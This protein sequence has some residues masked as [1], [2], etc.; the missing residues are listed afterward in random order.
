MP[1]QDVNGQNVSKLEYFINADPGFG[2]GVNVP[3]TASTDVTANFQVPVTSFPKGFHQLF[4]RSFVTPYQ[5]TIDGKVFDKGGWSLTSSRTF[6]KETFDVAPGTF[7]N[8]T[9]GEYFADTDPGFG[10]GVN[11]PVTQGADLTNV[12][13]AFDVT[14]LSTGFHNLFVRFK[15][16]AGKWGLTSVRSF[17]KQNLGNAGGILPNVVKG[18]YFADTD[19]GFGKGINLPF[20]AGQDLTN[21]A[22]S[23]DV[24][25]LTNGFHNI[26]TRFQDANGRWSLTSS[27]SFYKQTLD[28]PG[29]TLPNIIKGEYFADTDPGFGKGVNIP[30]TQAQDLTN[31]AFAFNITALSNGF[32]NLFV[33]F[34]DAKGNWGQTTSRSFYKQ[35]LE[36][37]NSIPPNIVQLEYFVDTD[38]GFN[39]GKKVSITAGQ[40]LDMTFPLN[41]NE[42]SVGN[43]T[44]Y[45]RAQDAKGN[46][47]LVN[48]GTFKVEP[49]S[50]LIVSLGTL[51]TN[52]CAGL[53]VKVP[54]SVNASFGSNNIFTAQLSDASGGFSN[55]VNIGNFTGTTNDTVR[56]TIPAN[57][58]AGSLYRIRVIAS[59]PFDTSGA[60]S[61]LVIK[62]V[63]EQSF[64]ITGKTATCIG[65]QAYSASSIEP[66]TTFS[67][68]L[69]GGGTM[70]TNGAN[71]TITWTTAGTHTVSLTPSN[72]CGNGQVRTLQVTVFTTAPALV[73]TI[74]VNSRL[75]TASGPVSTTYNGYQWYLNNVIINGAT[76]STYNAVADGSYSVAFT[77]SCGTGSVSVAV[78]MST[79]QSQ[80]I[81]FDPITTKVFGVAPFT[82]KAVASSGLAVTYSIVSGPATI[83]GST[84][85]I[86]GAGVVTVRAN[87]AGNASYN[88]AFADI[89]FT[90]DKAPATITLNTLSQVYTGI[91]KTPGFTTVPA[92]LQL[93]FT[94]NGSATPPVNAGS[95]TVVA[96]V[97]SANYSGTSQGTF[98]ITKATNLITLESIPDKEYGIS[99]FNVVANASSGLPVTLSLVTTPTGIAS[100]SA[101]T[102]SIT[103]IGSVQVNANQAGDGNYLP[104]T[105]VSDLFVINKGSQLVLLDP[106]ADR[107]YE[108]P[109][110]SV[111]ATVSTGLPLT[112]SITTNPLSGVASISGKVITL[113][114]TKGSVTVKASQAGNTLYQPASSERTFNVLGKSQT[115]SFPA[116]SSKVFGDAPFTISATASSGL[117]VVFYI[118]SGPATI[119]GNTITLTGSG[120]VVVQANQTGNAVYSQAPPI[121]QAFT[122]IKKTV[123]LAIQT[124]ASAQTEIAPGDS[125][126]LTWK[127]ANLGNGP[128]FINWTERIYMQSTA[129]DNRTLLQQSDY[130]TAGQLPNGQN[131]S[132][133]AKV[134]IPA[135]FNIGAQGVFVVEVVPGATIEE[136]AATLANNT[137]IQLTPWNIKKLLSIILS[138]NELT[139][140]EVNG[141]TATIQRTGSLA[142]SL[143]VNL[144]LT[145]AS[146]FSFPAQAVIPAGQSGT[147]VV[148]KALNNVLPEGII[149]DTLRATSTG[150][151]AAKAGLSIVDDDK[152]NLSFANLPLT[153]SEG[154][155]ATFQVKTNLAPKS[156]LEVFLT[157]SNQLRLPVPASVIIPVGSLSVNVNFIL[158]QDLV[159]EIDLTATLTAGAANHNSANGTVQVKDDDLPNLALVFQTNIIAESGGYYAT[160]ATLKRTGG[161]PVAFS[162]LLSSSLSNTLILPAG[163]SLEANENEKT[164][165]V[166]VIDNALVDGLRNVA[167]TASISVASCGCS[168]PPAT[169]GSVTANINVSDND[170]P[171][172]VLTATPLTLPEGAVYGAMLRVTRNTTT[173]TAVTVNLSSSDLTEATVP[174]S[175]I[176]PIGASFAEVPVTT[177]NDGVADGNQ[178]VYF[179]ATAGGFS[180][181]SVWVVVSDLNKPDLQI[182][183]VTLSKDSVQAMTL[184][185]YQVGVKNTGFATASS[186]VIMR[187]Y[188]SA[189]NVI[190]NNDSLVTVDTIPNAIPIGST[191]QVVNA[192]N[193]PNLPG[194]YKMIF[195]VNADLGLTELLL[196]NNISTPVNLFIKPDYTAT[197]S[198]TPVYVL[199]GNAVP[200]T[201]KALKSNGTP[202]T[203][204]PVE[205]YI[206]TQGFRRTL[207][208]TT[209][210]TGTYA[211]SFVP[212]INESGHY[213][214]GA[215]FPGIGSTIEQDAF[216]IVGV[217]VNN[218]EIA[219]FKVILNDTLRGSLSVTNL[220]NRSL[221]NFSLLPVSLPGGAYIRFE[222]VPSFAG[223]ATIAL[224]Y[225][226]SGASLSPGVNFEVAGLEAKSAEGTI[227][228]VEAFYYCQAPSAYIVA[229]ITKITVTASQTNKERLVEFRLVNK[230]QGSTGKVQLQLPQVN[231]MTA[232]TPKEIPFLAFGDTALVIL[233]FSAL[234]EVPFNFPITGNI[235]IN[236]AN[237]NSIAL[238]YS[239]EKVAESKGAIKIT[240]TNQF[241]YYAEGGPK[242]KDAF[243]QVKNYF[244]GVV[245]AEGYSDE[246]GVFAAT[247]IPEGKHRISVEKDKHLPYNN[248]ITV[249][250]ADTVESTV[251]LNYQ[252]ITF[253]WNVVPTAIEDK[254]DITLVTKF[255]TN[256]PIPVVTIDM[257]KSVPMLSGTETYAF[258]VTL[259]N[260]GLITAKDVALNLPVADTRYEYLTNYVPGDLL[261]Q[262]SIQVPVIMK[263]RQTPLSG[264]TGQSS[265]AGISKFLNMDPSQYMTLSA[266]GETCEDYVGVVYWYTCNLATGL[267]QQSATQF[268]YEGE[269]CT[270]AGGGEGTSYIPI[271]YGG[272]SYGGNSGYPFCASC[273]GITISGSGSTPVSTNEK[274]S[275]AQCIN[276]LIGAAAGC[277]S[278]GASN[279]VKAALEA[280]SVGSCIVGSIL[281][282][283]AA[284]AVK[285]HPKFPKIPWPG[286]VG[287][288]LDILGAINTCQQSGFPGVGGGGLAAGKMT[289]NAAG[290]ANAITE[291]GNNLQTA[292]DFFAIRNKW[293]AE[294]YQDLASYDGLED[295]MSKIDQQ[296]ANYDSILPVL[297]AAI[298]VEMV[299]YDLPA[300]AMNAFFTRW[301]TS[302]YAV[303]HGILKPNAQYPDIINWDS[304]K[305]WS[306]SL[307]ILSK[308]AT[309]LGYAHIYAMAEGEYASLTQILDEQST[310]SVC[311]SVTVQF[312]QQL[313]MTR[314]AFEGTLEIFNGHPSESMDSLTLN[315]AIKDPNGIPANGHFEIQTK[316]LTNIAD[317]TG[318]GTIP[319]QEKG[320]IKILFIPELTAAPTV[321]VV[322]NFGGSIRYWD[323]YVSAMV[324]MPLSDVALTV[325]PSPNLFLHYFME[326]NILSDDPLTLNTI[327]PTIPAELAV[328][329]ENLG[330]G[331]AVNMTISSAQPKIVE[332]EKGLAINFNLV[333]SNFQGQPKQLGVND[334]NFGTIPALQTR[335]GQW[336]FTSS[337][338]GKFV[339]YEASVVHAN[340]FGNPDL[341]L[342]K[343]VKLHELT[344]SI[345]LY[346]SLDDGINDFLVNDIFDVADRPD[347]IYFS[348]GNRTAKVS[349][350][351]S[352]SFSSNV[353]PPTFTNVLTVTP[354]VAGWNYIKLTDPG[355]RLFELKSV[356]RSDGQV[357]PLNNAWLTFVT[358][359]VSRAPVYEN[360]FHFVDTFPSVTPVTYTVVWKPVNLDVPK[361][362]SI[363][364]VPAQVSS[365]QVSNIK[366]VFNKRIDPVTFNYQDLT[367][368]FQGGPNI[369]NASVIITQVDS[370]S[371]NI[372]LS[373]LTTGNGFYALTVQAAEVA[374]VYGIKGTAGKQ[375]TWT[376]FLT[377]PTVQAFLGI[378]ESR[379]ASSFDTV[380]VLFN[381]PMDVSTV[382]PAKFTIRKNGV[383]QPSSLLIDSIRSANKLVYLSGLKNILTQSAVYE[384]FVDLPNMKSATQV[385]GAQA[386][387]LFLT[388]DNTGP[389]V[390]LEKS[391]S[392]AIDAQHVPY[393]KLKFDENAYSF[394]TGA[395]QLTW[396][397]ALQPIYYSLLSNT[398]LKTWIAGNFGMLTYPDGNYT[399]S[400]NLA[401][402][403]DA[404]GNPGIGTQK[405]EWI[406]NRSSQ[407][408][409]TGLTVTPDLGFSNSDGI[410]SSTAVNASFNLNANALKVVVSQ[411]DLSGEVVLATLNNVASG[412]TSLPLN[413]FTGGNTSIKITAT[414]ANGG[415][416][417][418]IKTLYIDPD[419]LTAE[420]QF[421]ENQS[422]TRQVDTL[423]ILLSAKLLTNTGFLNA[424]TVK[425]NGIVISKTGLNFEVVNDTLYRVKGMRVVNSTAG[426][427]E[428]SLNL[429]SLN[430]YSSGKSGGGSS[431]VSWTVLTSN[432]P[433]IAKAGNDLIQKTAGS[434]LL[435]GAASYDPDANPITYEWIAPAGI[436]LNNPASATPSFSVSSVNQGMTYSF[437]LI[438]RDGASFSTDAVQVFVNLLPPPT[439]TGLLTS[440]CIPATTSL[441][442]GSPTGGVFSGPGISGN[443]FNPSVAGTGTHQITYTKDGQ[444]ATQF[445]TVNVSP[446][447]GVNKTISKC[448]VDSVD[449]TK[450]FVTTGLTVNW[451]TVKPTAVYDAG[452][453]QLI[454]ANASG[455]KD[456]A[457]VTVTN[458]DKPNL[459]PDKLV[460]KCTGEPINIAALFNT[461]GLT[462]IWNT[463][464]A[465]A[466]QTPGTYQLVVTNANGCK[467]TALVTVSNYDKPNLGSDKVISK[468]AGEIINLNSL[469]TTTGLTLAWNTG[470]PTAMQTPGIYQLI[471]TNNNGCKDTALVTLTNYDKPNLGADKMLAKC[472][473]DSVDLTALFT[474][475]GLTSNW[476][477]ANPSVVYKPGV[478][479]LI[480]TSING[481]K[482]TA[483]VTVNENAKPNIGIDKSVNKCQ[484]DSINLTTLFNTT[485]LTTVWN[486][487]NPSA[488]YN[489]GIYRL[490]VTNTNGC[491]DTALVTVNNYSKPD[492]GAD[493]TIIIL[494]NDEKVSISAIYNTTGLTAQWTPSFIGNVGAGVYRLVVTNATGCRDTAYVTVKQNVATWTGAISPDWHEAGNWDIKQVPDLKTHVI[495]P[496]ATPLCMI[497]KPAVAASVQQRPGSI[498][499]LR[500]G[501]AINI[502]ERCTSL[503][504]K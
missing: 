440:Y 349:P 166:G 192:I 159:P 21:V 343:G 452:V 300:T 40:T 284:G 487:I 204:V 246:N 211:T 438:V 78:V 296:V 409:I 33:R 87:Q 162:A 106:I 437:L 482:D 470:T 14:S 141:I 47:S 123:D 352:G 384:L 443:T 287:C 401:G 54:F 22:F 474:T 71:A 503:P 197:A 73:P 158:E 418:F 213:S 360:R 75:L 266:S 256:V 448:A 362:D 425:R 298:Q 233:K 102:I 43:H 493:S 116:L 77:N 74:S 50:E 326:R 385:A 375:V 338:L 198:V 368:T 160:T 259:T 228:K 49:P 138:N 484:G 341:S 235:G 57:T 156:P 83:A 403:K 323:P 245:Y 420:W 5:L 327:E 447:I 412:I 45:I 203:N 331:P 194:A 244:S 386:Q 23:Y 234:D 260:H 494:C 34:Q 387:S 114:G 105:M 202:A 251:F 161:N 263:R 164:F 304:V 388:V 346:G 155:A 376:Q 272:D 469:F 292:V 289:Q 350:A 182:P 92:D 456:T 63:P 107:T 449:L 53:P 314:E 176:I 269:T 104:A 152:A 115:I 89:S 20:T 417:T 8:I 103:G 70:Q 378:P 436:I 316:S 369:M 133:A 423:P 432:L 174:A 373:S 250:P 80:T 290:P 167:V 478:Y 125:V 355:N 85:T 345:K 36:N 170:G 379:L 24:T 371:F 109:A 96:T 147:P 223:N 377:V 414:G 9:Q 381:L 93:T 347:I 277:A 501:Q 258:N 90:V 118:V 95:Y 427:Y 38:P 12:S 200:V 153:I 188:L 230:G 168:A 465:L 499:F 392:G 220:S 276:D 370:A 310:Q 253:S 113:L 472:A 124:V 398:D 280:V 303:K 195:E 66:N 366:V 201:G 462:A 190:D 339:S 31:V 394:N 243:V 249:N 344:K 187:G 405:I 171:T 383:V 340:S 367:L 453:Y 76:S 145:T 241:T 11:I 455:C 374:D 428:I 111:N 305:R 363:N 132:R 485:G 332:N 312:S 226:I 51:A 82:V 52:L 216:D 142:T 196:T 180:T 496:G 4:V 335:I 26:Y 27:R 328:M 308:K 119:L 222:T 154:G 212:M 255:E 150:Y 32:H 237:G 72:S 439:F 121:Q 189:D 317:I 257:P 492:L 297:Q 42:I 348:Q 299:G 68:N 139:E 59:S 120:T 431:S 397:G 486:T 199:R 91:A 495:I 112:Y 422:L 451:N 225:K 181:G 238:P 480:V 433:P 406:V 140:G 210:A 419:A 240:V 282:E 504:P 18:E 183:M 108:D 288:A 444:V 185:N 65:A 179:Q 458:Y 278:G 44:L 25:A 365:T 163:V 357:I 135:Q 334:I 117:P 390:T 143:T 415:I 100:V 460:S 205:V 122:V 247:G 207:I 483:L 421:E 209:D 262:Q 476:N 306:D 464:N 3:I 191:Y 261:A 48:S 295:F 215:S 165:N 301:N 408:L 454:V 7:L 393:I 129:G 333:G 6:Y 318:T 353:L 219:Q 221:S 407:V 466:I 62:R 268:T 2:K 81:V 206:L 151:I 283:S 435:N 445:T 94:Y 473:A 69:S 242:V 372:N 97:A 128:S 41:M 286:P 169:A 399:F 265:I 450:L 491:R 479:Q 61:Q 39:K 416:G 468:C 10:K 426:N 110:F 461:T 178:Q 274:K 285:C 186:G 402:V 429:V 173:T 224:S 463:T 146:R 15:D 177:I 459:G 325:N 442:T 309:A 86:T 364:G 302:V 502:R 281:D 359:P 441:L 19:P 294:Y 267:W 322:Y 157:S 208:A 231:W 475:T 175:V 497:S 391:D 239:F 424:I 193:A 98:V 67:W 382:T 227:Q 254:Y 336:Y 354:S 60:S 229:D 1:V 232:V 361:I 490:I 457:L 411:V 58:P 217:R 17:Y 131:I 126:A 337:L 184:F 13:F 434:V 311:A 481:C 351:T 127:V 214:V 315:L 137:G 430:K 130:S 467:D 64:S 291:I 271:F 342:V 172:L 264:R 319:S 498:L 380:Q 358:L 46:W 134:L 489:A 446:N 29:G 248:T 28:N 218:N 404:A 356:T 488:V 136:D 149:T 413:L 148:I 477:T 56:A 79:L 307:I 35:S 471:V 389:L 500:S 395:L 330:Y 275:C 236:S 55:P 321:P 279:G 37:I 99:P 410:T 252:A 400:I 320:L 101:K 270:G 144:G 16:A 88:P 324:T 84:V 30:I 329:V 293:A 273:P 396:N 313:T